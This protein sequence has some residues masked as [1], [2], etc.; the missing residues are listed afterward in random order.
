MLSRRSL[1]RSKSWL[2][3]AV[4]AVVTTSATAQPQPAAGAD[5]PIVEARE[6]LRKKDKLRLQGL[7]DRVVAARHPLASWVDYWELGSRLA[8]AQ[9]SEL[10]AFF[11]RWSGS[12]VEDRLRNDWLLELGRRRD[13]ANFAREHPRYRMNDDREVQ[14][15]ALLVD[16]LAGR[17]VKAAA[18]A[19]WY[20]QRDLDDGCNALATALAEARKLKAGE[21]WHEMRL[22][23]DANR[24]R[25]ARAAA[26]LLGPSTAAAIG[27]VLDQ[28]ARFLKR[29]LVEPSGQRQELAVLALM[30]LAASD[31]DAAQAALEAG[32]SRWLDDD[33][34][35]L[36]WATIGRAL[37]Q[38]LSDRA[39][40]AY[41]Q[42]WRRQRDEGSAPRW[43]DDTLAWNVRAALRSPRPDRERWGRVLQAIAA[44]SAAELKDPAWAYW[45]ARALKARARSDAER[46]RAAGAF[47]PLAAGVGY[48]AL[49]AAQE[50]GRPAS[51]PPAPPP[52]TEAELEQAAQTPGLQRGL[53]MARIG[54]RDEGRREW[55]FS[56]RG[57]GDRELLAAAQFACQAQDWQLC[58]NTS[59]R[60]REQ[61]DLRQRYPMPFAAEITARA[62]DS[63]L[64]PAFVFGLIRQE[65][66]FLPTLRSSAGAA[67]LMQLMPAT[68][69]WTARKLGLPF[70]PEQVTDVDTNLRLGTT[71]LKLVLDD[72]TGSQPLAAAAYNAGPN[73][74]RRW[75][76]GPV[77]DTA[78]WAENIPFN[79]TRDYVKKVLANATIYSHL[80][81]VGTVP[82]AQ[83]LGPRI[84]PRDA[85]APVADTALP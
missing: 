69:R 78:V 85:A 10:E 13:W 35:A 31:P 51:L 83:R 38:R 27:E 72:F 24:P 37:A 74:P 29:R 1:H 61:V 28:P 66:R 65:T 53:Q 45:K 33:D 42:A 44:M 80:L 7:R 23:V 26:A 64:D 81:G 71:Y 57:L 5:D 30:R 22:S 12:Y 18:L 77:L 79:E 17:E 68:A 75:R 46:E 63:G 70:Q 73:R 25:A 32:W 62:R 8:E 20:A 50:L 52:L 4:T 41:Q 14:C 43:S 82:L 48:Y 21:I 16:H 49:L 56:L 39:Y 36:A 19:T 54:L 2:L 60:T 11:E 67:G 3:A 59:E 76:E 15:Y 40:D 55:N 6:A 58:I 9:Q 84:G 34:A 47:E